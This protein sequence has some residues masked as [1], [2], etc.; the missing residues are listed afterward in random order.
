MSELTIH[1]QQAI[2]GTLAVRLA[3]YEQLLSQA[4][5]GGLDE[6][7]YDAGKAGRI[8]ADFGLLDAGER[9]QPQPAPVNYDADDATVLAAQAD[10]LTLLGYE[11]GWYD[12]AIQLALAGKPVRE[13]SHHDAT[14]LLRDLSLTPS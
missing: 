5:R 2:I 9:D 13:A 1:F 4:L 8:L 3:E 12:A 11:L 10:Q 14:D 7:S 6:A